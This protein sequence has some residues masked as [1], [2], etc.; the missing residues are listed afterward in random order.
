ME[1]FE[2]VAA[3]KANQGRLIDFLNGAWGQIQDVKADQKLSGQGK[4]ERLR[5]VGALLFGELDKLVSERQHGV[6]SG[7]GMLWRDTK[8]LRERRQIYF[9]KLG[10]IDGYADA[11]NNSKVQ[12]VLVGKTPGSTDLNMYLDKAVKAGR[13]GTMRA[14]ITAPVELELCSEQDLER[15]R[16]TWYKAAEPDPAAELEALEVFFRGVKKAIKTIRRAIADECGVPAPTGAVF[17]E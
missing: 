17:V 3:A 14:L 10:K 9:D 11:L 13:E 5:D 15:H 12:D 16:E 1:R 7:F 6:L 8:A 2:T 4:D